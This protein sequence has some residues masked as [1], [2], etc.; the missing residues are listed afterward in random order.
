[1][2]LSHLTRLC[3]LWFSL[4]FYLHMTTIVSILF[5]SAV[6]TCDFFFF[7]VISSTLFIFFKFCFSLRDFLPLCS[8]PSP[9]IFFCTSLPSSLSSSI[10]QWRT[11]FRA[12]I[13]PQRSLLLFSSH[14]FITAAPP[15]SLLCSSYISLPPLT[16][17][18]SN[19]HTFPCPAFSL[20]L[21]APNLALLHLNLHFSC[22]P[23]LLIVM[24]ILS[25]SFTVSLNLHN[26][27]SGMTHMKGIFAT[28]MDES[29]A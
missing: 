23:F 6:L 27:P 17:P 29:T 3:S 25:C 24:I 4:L 10:G 2:Q 13:T 22:F 14:P 26:P 12:L 19:L 16:A 9:S 21:L 7:C 18:F 8:I 20:H 5:Y 28:S 11:G 15:F 1:M